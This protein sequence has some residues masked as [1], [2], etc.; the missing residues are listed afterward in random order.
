[1][2]AGLFTIYAAALAIWHASAQDSD[3]RATLSPACLEFNQ[4]I[5]DK[6]EN[7]QLADAEAA[8]STTTIDK[9][10]GSGQSCAWLTLSNRAHVI[11]LSGRF[12]E[13]ELLAEQSLR[14][15]DKLYPPNDPIR[16]RT[17][18][19][20]WSVQYQQGKFG[21]AR[22]TFQSMRKL[23]LNKPSDG[24]MFHG[25][26]A[27]QLQ[28]EGQYKEA[29]PEYFKALTATDQAGRG[30]TTEAAILLIGLATVQLI[31]GRYVDAGRT[32]DRALAIVHSAKD[33]IPMDRVSILGIRADLHSRQGKWQEA[34]EDMRL[35][36]SIVD[37]ETRL[38]PVTLKRLLVNYGYVLRKANRRKEARSIEARAA[39]IHAPTLTNA[40][41]D[42][43]ELVSK[44][45]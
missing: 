21:N 11:Y 32:L 44:E 43:T 5:V 13:A 24:A 28:A 6:L 41:V 29:E 26:A 27:T 38:D 15:Q 45:K 14:I 9:E 10:I 7:G 33:A 16:F 23:T 30:E 42:V 8:F 4:R 35:A 17:L 31:Q 1:M 12:I 18:Q 3:P 2:R 37:R 19:L 39:A 36:I 22:Q 20:L 34:E 40:V 25:A